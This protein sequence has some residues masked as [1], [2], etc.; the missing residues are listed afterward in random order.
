MTIQTRLICLAIVSILFSVVIS[1][2]NLYMGRATTDA[3]QFNAV[4]TTAMR[5][6]MEADQVHDALRADV[7]AA[8][9]ASSQKQAG[10][11]AGIEKELA[12][13]TKA[14]SKNNLNTC[15]DSSIVDAWT[16]SRR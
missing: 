5:H 15:S 9:L 1:A 3:M 14:L 13:H 16:I 7:L 10:E 6:H 8:V 4:M 12:E 2:S 11:R